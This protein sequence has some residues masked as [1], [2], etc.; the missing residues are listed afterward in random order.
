MPRVNGQRLLGDL[1]RL[2]AFGA[3][4][5]GVVRLALS[6]VDLAAREWLAG[7]MNEAGL[8]AAI[9]GVGTVYGRARQSGRALL[10]GSHTDTQPSGG[11]LD[12]AYGV[13]CGLE[14]ARA[15]REDPA[16]SDLAIDVASWMDEEGTYA[17][18]LAAS[19]ARWSTIS[20][21]APATQKVKAFQRH[22][23]VPAMPAG[24]A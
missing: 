17:G 1:R 13:I 2:R 18:Y 16:T 9:D 5:T 7:R 4:G 8:E 11:W 24:R 20:S 6:P 19:R 21:P 14:I 3:T 15:L 22:S 12:G 10:I 23:R